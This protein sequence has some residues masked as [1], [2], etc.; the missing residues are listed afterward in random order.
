[1]GVTSGCV[2]SPQRFSSLKIPCV[3]KGSIIKARPTPFYLCNVPAGPVPFTSPLPRGGHGASL[4]LLQLCKANGAPRGNLFPITLASRY[5]AFIACAESAGRGGGVV[6]LQMSIDFQ[7]VATTTRQRRHIELPLPRGSVDGGTR[8]L[9]MGSLQQATHLSV[10]SAG[11]WKNF[12]QYPI[13]DCCH[14]M[15]SRSTG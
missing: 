15:F 11:Q 1:M 9:A 5:S 12:R 10:E 4:L 13:F 2:Q 14:T 8:W 7:M 6:P 3:V